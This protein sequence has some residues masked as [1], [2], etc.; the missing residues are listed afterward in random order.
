[1]AWLGIEGHDDVVEK[2]RRSLA[3]GRLASTYLFVGPA[4]IGK[5]TFSERL[6]QTLLCHEAPAGQMD[7]CG[8]CRACQQVLAKTHP[9]MICVSR[10]EI[11]PG[12][13]GTIC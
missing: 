5:R 12:S 1:M 13:A 9:D 11:G 6:A 8:R 10:L 7:P 3:R 2:F 4:A